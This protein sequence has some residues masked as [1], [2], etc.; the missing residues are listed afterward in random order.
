MRIQFSDRILYAILAI[1]TLAIRLPLVGYFNFVAFDGTFYLNQARALL[2]GSL[3]GG[4]FPVGYPLLVAPLI[5]IVRD[6]VVA[7]MV[8][9][10]CAAIGTVLL[11]YQLGK[12]FGTRVD[13]FIAAAVL[14]VTPLFIQT[15][16][17]TLSESVYVFWIMLTLALFGAGRFALAGLA[18]G[19]AAATR[20][21]ALAVAGVLGVV[22][23]ARWI[24]FGRDAP[25]FQVPVG[26]QVAGRAALEH[27]IAKRP[28]HGGETVRPVVPEGR[29]P[30]AE[31]LAFVR[32][33]PGRVVPDA[34]ERRRNGARIEA[35]ARRHPRRA[36][37][38]A[39]FGQHVPRGSHTV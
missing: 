34:R 33:Q 39:G 29:Q 10:T 2:H 7:G 17:L 24:V 3:S 9:S 14:A 18:V 13:A 22:L 38:H 23:L 36:I 1:L 4:A 11:L 27:A 5:P 6:P 19:M 16:L 8:V 32:P 28:E 12:R 37:R 20:P 35:D 31:A 25:Q 30:R 26:I 21:E 15:S